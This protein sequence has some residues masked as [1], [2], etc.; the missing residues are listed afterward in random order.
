MCRNNLFFMANN[1]SNEKFNNGTFQ[2]FINDKQG[3]SS[4]IRLHN[5]PTQ[6][7]DTFEL[8]DKK[9]KR[10]NLAITVGVLASIATVALSINK[11]KFIPKQLQK[12]SNTLK[13]KYRTEKN[14]HLHKFFAVTSSAVDRLA[15]TSTNF[16]TFRDLFVKKV[17]DKTPVTKKLREGIDGFYAFLN[18][19]PVEK[20]L[21]KSRNSYYEFLSSVEAARIQTEAMIKEGKTGIL[22]NKYKDIPIDDP[23]HPL[24]KLKN[25]I[26]RSR[27]KPHEL[28]MPHS[29]EKHFYNMNKDMQYLTQEISLKRFR[30]KEV[31]QG[32]LAENILE[33]R[34]MSFVKSLLKE[35]NKISNSFDDIGGYAKNRINDTNALIYQIKDTTSQKKLIEISKDLEK[36]IKT[37]AKDAHSATSRET[38]TQ[39]VR[40]KIKTFKETAELLPDSPI[41]KKLMGR[42]DEYDVLFKDSEPGELQEIRKLAGEVWGRGSEFDKLIK[43][44]ANKHIKDINTSFNCFVNM[45]DKQRD[46]VLGAGSMDIITLAAPAVGYGFALSKDKT[47]DERVDTTLELGLPV[48]GITGAYFYGLMRQMNGSKNFLFSLGVGALLNL[49]GASIYKKYKESPKENKITAQ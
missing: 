43:K 27:T 21:E 8:Q 32:L 28:I 38:V 37:Y 13:N 12:L 19:W 4:C 29:V 22:N 24:Q 6:S 33:K 9:K 40:E 5:I 23:R 49:M 3:Y 17:M 2:P 45:F 46:N 16:T 30:S 25:L 36:N 11:T 7:Q 42:I 44:S 35:K 15:K 10:S 47:N 20:S 14:K 34:R 39:N 18:K 41:K 31:F 1:I 48:A 26:S